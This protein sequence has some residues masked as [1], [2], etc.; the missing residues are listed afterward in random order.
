MSDT[1]TIPK[2]LL[3]RIDRHLVELHKTRREWINREEA[4]KLLG[5]NSRT[6]TNRICDKTITEDMFT[7]SPV[8]GKQ[9]FDKAKL[10]GL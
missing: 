4:C 8:N 9:Y 3:Q 2:A 1:I 7:V 5:W 10:L 6:L